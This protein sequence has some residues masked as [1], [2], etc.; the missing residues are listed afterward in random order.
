MPR[1]LYAIPFLLTVV[2]GNLTA[3]ESPMVK[4]KYGELEGE[5]VE[6]TEGRKV[7]AFL[8]IPYAKPPIGDLRF[9]KPQSPDRWEGIRSAKSFGNVCM[10]PVFFPSLN[11]TK[12]DEDCLF[13][14]VITPAWAPPDPSGFPVMMWIYGGAFYLGSSVEYGYRGLAKG[15]VAEGVIVVT[16]NYRLGLWGFLSTGDDVCPGNLG[17]WDQTKALEW[18]HDTIG[19][20]N[21]DSSRVTVFGISAGGASTDFLTL[22]P[23]SQNLFDRAIPM[24][25]TASAIWAMNPSV[26]EHTKELA[27]Q[28]DCVTSP[29]EA[30]IECLHN[31]SNADITSA[32]MKLGQDYNRLSFFRFTPVIDG[33]FLPHPVT[34]MRQNAPKKSVITGMA[35]VE[36]ITF[37]IMLAPL[38]KFGVTDKISME[39]FDV[40][41]N[42]SLPKESYKNAELLHE[43][44][45][46]QYLTDGDTH[47][48]TYLLLKYSQMMGDFLQV[49]PTYRDVQDM[50]QNNWT[51]HSYSFDYA[52]PASFSPGTRLRIPTHGVE[53]LYFFGEPVYASFQYDDIDESLMKKVTAM[54]AQFAKTKDPNLPQNEL[55]WPAV[56][57]NQSNTLVIKEQPEIRVGYHQQ[58]IAF[59]TKLVPTVENFELCDDPST[60]PSL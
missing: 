26:A 58:S 27:A 50:L 42:S 7:D 46:H 54:W 24:A 34:I 19:Q 48:S 1:L 59:W 3:R 30:M 36:G 28:L 49:V 10:Q 56:S 51:V 8:G 41:L 2:C 38:H 37:V 23:H 53:L 45:K 43:L 4:T 31:K 15:L 60:K 22:S 16:I 35:E 55:K 12:I 20:F 6:S 13:L 40:F 14:N 47:N 44:A 52:N 11:A 33:D 21:G 32:L 57:G 9:K 39:T 25:G 18:I 17:L 5:R 29:S